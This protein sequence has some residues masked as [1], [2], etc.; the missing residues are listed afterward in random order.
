MEYED[1][2]EIEAEHEAQE[3]LE[4]DLEDSEDERIYN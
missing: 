1:A 2:V 3:E 4:I